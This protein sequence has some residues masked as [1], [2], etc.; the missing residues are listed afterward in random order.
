[1][2][3]DTVFHMYRTYVLDT[4]LQSQFIYMWMFSYR[5]PLLYISLSFSQGMN[6]SLI[7][8]TTMT[9]E[10]IPQSTVLRSQVIGR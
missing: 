10:N 3:L 8:A 4:I 1:M 5:I 9:S 2:I 7:L 6:V